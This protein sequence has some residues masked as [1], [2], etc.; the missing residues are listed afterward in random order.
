ML[1]MVIEQFKNRDARPVYERFAE[2][3]PMMPDGLHYV[4]SWIETSYDRCFQLMETDDVALFDAW[5][6]EWKDLMD[7]EVIPVVT[8]AEA[9][10][11]FSTRS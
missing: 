6:A 5:I 1:F 8:S 11:V 7:F 9:R 10:S 4:D 3:G 2:K